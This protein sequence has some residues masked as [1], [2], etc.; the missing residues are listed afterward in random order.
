[1]V[2]VSVFGTR[3]IAASVVATATLLCGVV[4]GGEANAAPS[5]PLAW[6]EEAAG[7]LGKVRTITKVGNLAPSTRAELDTLDRSVADV[8]ARAPRPELRSAD[9]NAVLE[10][11]EASRNFQDVIARGNDLPGAVARSADD[12][13]TASTVQQRI[14]ERISEDGREILQDAACDAAFNMMAPDEKKDTKASGWTD[15]VEDTG[16]DPVAGA[17]DQYAQRQV[18]ALFGPGA[19]ALVRW[20]QY[21]TGI[22]EK[23]DRLT[24]DFEGTVVNP[25]PNGR[26]VITRAFVYYARACLKPPS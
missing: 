4:G 24:G 8:I 26:T 16:V 15:V 22:E 9:V 7:L 3:L 10:P 21:G 25:D 1:V 17:A 19:V 14:R 23:Y 20:E 6:L 18:A 2:Q 13:A 12:V 11:L 5:A